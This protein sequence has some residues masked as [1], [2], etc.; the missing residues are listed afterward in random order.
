MIEIKHT[1]AP[2]NIERQGDRVYHTPTYKEICRFSDEEMTD[3]DGYFFAESGSETL[4]NMYLITA[5]PEMFDALIAIIETNRFC[6]SGETNVIKMAKEAI[7][8][9]RGELNWN[10]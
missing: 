7:A 1:P 9:A 6:N 10:D 2:W 4:A 5:A 3:I 8:K